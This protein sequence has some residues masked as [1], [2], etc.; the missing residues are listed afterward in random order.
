VQNWNIA[1]SLLPVLLNNGHDVVCYVRDKKRFDS[2][3]YNSPSLSAIEIDFL[4]I[5]TLHNIPAYINAAYYLIHSIST[6]SG[7]FEAMEEESAINF[8][9]CIQQ[10]KARH[11]ILFEW[12][13]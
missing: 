5:E 10:T 11:V 6:S 7:N 9:N 1:Q 3:K 8:M 13:S 4:K 2:N 12:Y